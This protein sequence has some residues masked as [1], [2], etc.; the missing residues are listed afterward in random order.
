MIEVRIPKEITEY[1]EKVIFGLSIRQLMFFTLTIILSLF[2]YFVLTKK[3]GLSMDS[4]SYVIILESLPLLAI[5]FIKINGFTFE[6]Y[7]VLVIRHKLG[8]QKRKY[9][10]DLLIDKAGEEKNLMEGGRKK[11]A[12]HCREKK[13]RRKSKNIRE[14]I[15]F[16]NTKKDKKRKRKEALQQIKRARKEYRNT[17]QAE[18]KKNKKAKTT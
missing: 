3:L 6:K 14:A 1:K 5:G 4:A 11:N 18:K 2:S 12:K 7:A 9:K 8:I 13:E 16:I 15:L 17:K 10:T